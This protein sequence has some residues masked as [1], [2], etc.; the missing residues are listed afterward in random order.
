MT[1][2]FVWNKYNLQAAKYEQYKY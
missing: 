2:H 1:T